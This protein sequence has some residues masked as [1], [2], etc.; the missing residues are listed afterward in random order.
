MPATDAAKPGF[1][2][3]LSC[4]GRRNYLVGFFQA[5]LAA[6][7][8][9]G[10][11][12]VVDAS[13][14]APAMIEARERALSVPPLDDPRY[15]DSVLRL[16][17][18]K[19]VRLLVPLNDFELPG[20]ARQADRFRLVGTT[21]VVSTPDVV[22]LCFDKWRT[23]AR[24]GELGIPTAET[25]LGLDAAKAALRDGRLAFPLVVKP[26]WG[27][28]SIGV[29]LVRDEREL[30]LAYAWLERRLDSTAIGRAGDA[31]AGERIIVQQALSGQEFGVDIVNGIDREPAAVLIKR[32]IAMRA[33]ETDRAV[34]EANEAIAGLA[35]RVSTAL[36]P[37]GLIDCDAF[38][39]PEGPKILEL[40]PR[41]GGGYPF[42]QA[43]GADVPAALIAWARG[44]EAK[45][46]WLRLRLGVVAA[47]Y[48]RLAVRA[49]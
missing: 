49:V 47:K 17:E 2:V 12:Y 16:C 46:E 7:G 25:R 35:R 13:P 19:A 44:R 45:P 24:L 28:G 31:P 48:D 33:G 30:E 22:D 41:F 20:L 39:T 32:K 4:A 1:N 27:T 5:A 21:P 15:F 18:E 26:R 14:D 3:M 23:F 43:A 6:A 36:R 37:R 8:L 34:S 29:E 11:V 40:N 42:S 10:E 38:M 9:A